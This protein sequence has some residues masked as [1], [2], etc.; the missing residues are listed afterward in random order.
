[1]PFHL[2]DVLSG[3]KLHIG[4]TLVGHYGDMRVRLE[5][6]PQGLTPLGVGIHLNLRSKWVKARAQA[7]VD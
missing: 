1:M 5:M 4:T 2:R 3:C 6:I 7:L